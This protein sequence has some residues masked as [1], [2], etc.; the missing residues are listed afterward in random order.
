MIDPE[1]ILTM[2]LLVGVLAAIWLLLSLVLLSTMA[3][4]PDARVDPATLWP[5]A[6]GV[7]A[8]I[9]AVATMRLRKWGALVYG[10]AALSLVV[11]GSVLHIPAKP[12]DLGWG[13]PFLLVF[14]LAIV[15]MNW[16]SLRRSEG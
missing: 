1:A 5:L 3:T 4:V 6:A 15:A 16:S 8:I 14:F 11:R 10:I 7:L 9:G 13:Y 2:R 12:Y